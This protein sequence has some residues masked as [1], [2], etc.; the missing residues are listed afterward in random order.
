MRQLDNAKLWA[1][2]CQQ[3]SSFVGTAGF[4]DVIVGLSG[5]I[6]SSMVAA[7]ACQ[8]LGPSHV[9]GVLM[10]GPYSSEGSVRDAEELARRLEMPTQLFSITES[11]KVFASEYRYAFGAP[12]AGLA[13]E[14]TQARL[15][16]VALMALSNAQGW[17][18]LNTGNFSEAA[19]GYSTLYGDM[20]GA[21][22]PLGALYKTEVFA[23]AHWLD[24]EAKREGKVPP[25]PDEV[26]TKPPSAELAEGQSDEASLGM[27]YADLDEAL[28]AMLDEGISA[29]D[30]SPFTEEVW[31][32]Y[33]ANEFKRTLEPPFAQVH[34]AM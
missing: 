4:S 19:L 34:D 1:S 28:S 24:D 7:V 2:I 10:P 16:M 26:L 8:A 27:T 18:V 21:F 5:G 3:T 11:F 15:R 13:A 9:H 14:N 23:L 33:Q 20:V 30:I 25:I 17:L 12:L 22:A 29:A 31:R 6:D 32:R